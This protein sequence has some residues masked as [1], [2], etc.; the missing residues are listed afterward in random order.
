MVGF[1]TVAACEL[2]SAVV[3]IAVAWPPC[4]R[5]GSS[6]V[7]VVVVVV[8]CCGGSSGTT[9]AGSAWTVAAG[10]M[11]L[12]LSFS[13]A[14][15]ACPWLPAST[16]LATFSTACSMM[17]DVWWVCWY[18]ARLSSSCPKI[19]QLFLSYYIPCLPQKNSPKKETAVE[20]SYLFVRVEV[21]GWRQY[22]NFRKR[23]TQH[24]RLQLQPC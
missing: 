13:L 3:S 17:L 14:T 19:L 24:G 7:V 5:A 16:P 22:F 18:F 10:G 4:S 12:S 21:A 15:V 11:T 9:S 20:S 8:V 6:I 2:G 23:I 1:T